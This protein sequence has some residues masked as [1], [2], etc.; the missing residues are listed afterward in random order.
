MRQWCASAIPVLGSLPT[1]SHEVFDMFHQAEP[2]LERSAGGLGIGLTLARR[3]V[4]MHEGRIDIRS[5]AA[6]ARVPR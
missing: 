1:P 2:T 5:P 4:E 3:L 6:R